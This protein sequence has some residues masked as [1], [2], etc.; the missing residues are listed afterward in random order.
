VLR[1]DEGNI[2]V[3]AALSEGETSHFLERGLFGQ[4]VARCAQRALDIRA[5]EAAHTGGQEIAGRCGDAWPLARAP[6][7]FRAVSQD[8]AQYKAAFWGMNGSVDMA[9][10]VKW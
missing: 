5:R 6:F 1:V 2:D 3:P 10:S 8:A 4:D 7:E 9:S